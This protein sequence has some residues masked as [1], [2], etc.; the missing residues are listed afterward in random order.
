MLPERKLS[1]TEL[2]K[3][4]PLRRRKEY[5]H[6]GPGISTGQDVAEPYEEGVNACEDFVSA[7]TIGTRKR[8]VDS[9]ERSGSRRDNQNTSVDNCGVLSAYIRLNS[10]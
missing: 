3:L 4:C 2:E 5:R 9:N 10:D 1:S 7:G 6:G 8:T